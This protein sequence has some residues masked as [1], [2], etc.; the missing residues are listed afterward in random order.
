[1][2]GPSLRLRLW[3]VAPEHASFAWLG[4]TP[5][6]LQHALEEAGA[7]FIA[8]YRAAL[9]AESPAAVPLKGTLSGFASEGVAM[10]AA[11]RD[12]WS[13]RHTHWVQDVLNRYEKY[14]HTIVT[15]AGWGLAYIPRSRWKVVLDQL[16]VNLRELAVDG[17]GFSDRYF[18]RSARRLLQSGTK[19]AYLQGYGRAEWFHASG[20]ICRLPEV[21]PDIAAGVGLAYIYVGD[22]STD[23]ARE[24]L[25]WADTCRQHLLQGACWAATAHW[26][27]D[28]ATAGSKKA[29]YNLTGSTLDEAAAIVHSAALGLRPAS[30]GTPAYEV[31]RRRVIK[32][33]G[34]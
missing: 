24:L 28:T 32:R 7:A 18:H 3:G 31:W 21:T 25:R 10:A 2:I 8:G 9:R 4:I 16:P 12:A 1:M 30:D 34:I 15:G 23:R 17:L 14:E 13:V 29:L 26:R 5:G 27:A 11:V 20:E 33:M 19:H 6:P 22:D